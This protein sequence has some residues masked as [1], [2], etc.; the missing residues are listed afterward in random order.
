MVRTMA[1]SLGFVVRMGRIGALRLRA[2]CRRGV[3]WVAFGFLVVAGGG[4]AGELCLQFGGRCGL[5]PSGIWGVRRVMTRAWNP[6][7]TL[8]R[9][10]CWM[11]C[12][13]EVLVR[14]VSGC[15]KKSVILLLSCG[16]SDF[17]IFWLRTLRQSQE[18]SRYVSQ[19]RAYLLVEVRQFF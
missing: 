14:L 9:N 18:G 11:T 19:G 1:D 8:R 4:R 2:G 15:N 5:L 16:Q 6:G 12:G 7:R 17:L 3:E 13:W 10:R